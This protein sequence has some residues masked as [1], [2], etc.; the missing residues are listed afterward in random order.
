[1]GT[2]TSKEDIL[3][4]EGSCKCGKIKIKTYTSPLLVVNCHCS[5]CRSFTS[6][7]FSSTTLYLKSAVEIEGKESLEFENTSIQCNT[8]GL[9]RCRCSTCKEPVIDIGRLMLGGFTCPSAKLLGLDRWP[10]AG[11]AHLPALSREK[12]RAG[13][14]H[15]A[16]CL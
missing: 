6:K 4:N 2:T 1:M 3:Q 16:P 7:P 5:K 14:R 15:I 8:I 9:S 13:G 12:E 10:L 11:V